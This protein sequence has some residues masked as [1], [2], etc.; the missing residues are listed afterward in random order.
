MIYTAK[1]QKAALMSACI[2]SLLKSYGGFA[3][4][5]LLK[6]PFIENKREKRGI[7]PDISFC[8]SQKKE[9]NTVEKT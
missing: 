4:G 7:V 8:V 9:N 3:R 5:T 2:A 1:L 6:A